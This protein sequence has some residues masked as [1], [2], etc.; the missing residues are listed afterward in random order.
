M[1][2]PSLYEIATEFAADA[3]KLQELDLDP[4]TLSDTLESL[5]GALE[6]K[7]QNTA[8][9]VRNLESMALAMK[10]AEDRMRERRKAV[11]NRAAALQTYILRCM[12]HAKISKIESPA[13]RISVRKNPPSVVIDAASQIPAKYW[14]F[15]DP[16]P[17]EIDKKAINEA[18]AEGHEVPGA[19]TEQTERLEIR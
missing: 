13:L 19:H 16:P 8:M 2:L 11:E 3:E 9:V 10:D 1:T 12:Q 15:P 7:A 18:I 17:A 14:R 4:Q 5:S 6:Q